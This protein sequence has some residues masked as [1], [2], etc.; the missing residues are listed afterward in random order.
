MIQQGK[1]KHPTYVILIISLLF[2]IPLLMALILY[3]E[4]ITLGKNTTNHGQLIIPPFPITKLD[5]YNSKGQLL[6]NQS[7]NNTNEE[8]SPNKNRTNGKWLMLYLYP[9]S[10]EQKCEQGLYKMRQIRLATGKNRDRLERAILT[11]SDTPSDA[12]LKNLLSTRYKGTR[13][14]MVSRQHFEN[15]I[16]THVHAA[17]ANKKGALFIAD[18]LGNILMVYTSNAK[19]KGIFKD[20]QRLLKVSQIG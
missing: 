7:K 15:T 12:K 1:R 9:T 19:P 17:Y 14:L 10:C 18:P 4:N 11:Y 8:A 3:I 20:I 13:H 5:L 6:K 2:L 16:Q